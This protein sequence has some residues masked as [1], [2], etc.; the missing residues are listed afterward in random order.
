MDFKYKSDMAFLGSIIATE[1][2][3]TKKFVSRG[4]LR[5]PYLERVMV[6]KAIF[7]DEGGEDTGRISEILKL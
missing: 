7:M 2:L 3:A 1:D 4:K 5:Q 6:A